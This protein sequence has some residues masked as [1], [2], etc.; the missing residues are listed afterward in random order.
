MAAPTSSPSLSTVPSSPPTR[1]VVPPLMRSSEA[2]L[3][4]NSLPPSVCY[5]DGREVGVAP[6]VHVSVTPGTHIV[7]FVLPDQ[8]VTKTI[9]VTVDAGETKLATAKLNVTAATPS[10]PE[11]PA[12][13]PLICDPPYIWDDGGNR[14]YNVD[15]L[16]H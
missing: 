2:F 5:L 9:L 14:R 7:T 15:C 16:R 12:G 3:N 6:R 1:A 11:V 4:I 10:T 13:Q 8:G